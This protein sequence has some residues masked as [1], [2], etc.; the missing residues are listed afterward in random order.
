MSVSILPFHKPDEQ[1]LA[2]RYI[3]KGQI[4]IT[5]DVGKWTDI[6]R[7]STNVRRF[8][9]E[10]VEL[11]NSLLGVMAW[12]EDP[13]KDQLP[14]AALREVLQRQQWIVG[15]NILSGKLTMIKRCSFVRIVL[16]CMRTEFPFVVR[17]PLPYARRSFAGGSNVPDHQPK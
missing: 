14:V 11:N 13:V 9:P 5:R 3:A 4:D 15:G 6:L 10:G 7:A 12:A 16:G 17:H 8:I 2:Q 1:A